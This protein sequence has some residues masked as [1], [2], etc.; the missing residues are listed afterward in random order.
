LRITR[1]TLGTVTAATAALLVLAARTAVWEPFTRLFFY[2]QDGLAAVAQI[3]PN[4][5]TTVT[6]Y[7]IGSFGRWTHVVTVYNG[8]KSW[9]FFYNSDTGA[10]ATGYLTGRF[11]YYSNR[12]VAAISYGAGQ[13]FYP[14]W[15]NIASD[16]RGIMWFDRRFPPGNQ[17]TF[18][19]G[20]IDQQGYFRQISSGAS[21]R[22]IS[23]FPSRPVG[24][25]A[26]GNTPAQ[27]NQS[28][29]QVFRNGALVSVIDIISGLSFPEPYQYDD[30]PDFNLGACWGNRVLYYE[31]HTGQAAVCKIDSQFQIHRTAYYY[32]GTFNPS[33][34][35][36]VGTRNSLFFYQ[37][38]NGAGMIGQFFQHGFIPTAEFPPGSFTTGWDNIVA[39]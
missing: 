37:R 33:W 16:Q 1:A 38:N 21:D 13:A 9:L 12:F 20:Y 29:A 23:V 2:R 39:Y 5:V 24:F 4:Q 27:G 8:S 14:H 25:V 18:A 28:E 26:S 15:V 3:T 35:H 10:A 19:Y 30:A 32:R 11:R 34:S 7:P 31:A 6:N 17:P 36:I 22:L